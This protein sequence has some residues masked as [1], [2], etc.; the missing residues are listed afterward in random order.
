MAHLILQGVTV[1]PRVADK[2]PPGPTKLLGIA[3]NALSGQEA[4]QFGWRTFWKVHLD[5]PWGKLMGKLM[6]CGYGFSV[7]QLLYLL[8]VV[9][10]SPYTNYYIWILLS[11]NGF[12]AISGSINGFNTIYGYCY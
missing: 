12:T 2:P 6:A 7:Y 5:N 4:S 1:E 8:Y 3:R 9:S 10:I 11:I